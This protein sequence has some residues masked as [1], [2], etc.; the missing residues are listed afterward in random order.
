MPTQHHQILSPYQ[1]W[2]SEDV[3]VMLSYDRYGILFSS[4]SG[5][6][7]VLKVS[8]VELHILVNSQTDRKDCFL[9]VNHSCK[10]IWHE[11]RAYKLFALLIQIQSQ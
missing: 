10:P 3:D 6:Y 1:P 5:N 2:V 11:S 9:F 7:P 8:M 4:H